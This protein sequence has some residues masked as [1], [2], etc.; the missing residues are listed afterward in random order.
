MFIKKSVISSICKQTKN[1][2]QLKKLLR[3]CHDGESREM[4]ITRGALARFRIPDPKSGI[5]TKIGSH[6]G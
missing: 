1:Y 3:D 2:A 5:I 4:V 6:A